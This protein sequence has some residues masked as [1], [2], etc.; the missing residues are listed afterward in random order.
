MTASAPID[1]MTFEEYLAFE[2]GSDLKH[3]YIRGLVFAMAGTT[4][5]HNKICR[6]VVGLLDRR[7]DGGPCEPFVSDVKLRV[8][9]TDA[10]FYP[11]VFVVCGDGGRDQDVYATDARLVI[12]VLSPSTDAHDRGEKLKHYIRLPGLQ[13]YVLVDSR[14]RSIEIY[15]RADEGW[16][17][18]PLSEEQPVLL[19]SVDLRTTFDAIYRRVDLDDPADRPA[20][21]PQH[22]LGET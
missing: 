15:R 11:D 2:E 8:A 21:G 18:L 20:R 7:L 12:E 14:R 13:E 5:A 4:R 6:N 9:T 19:T 17:Y 10:T 16:S 22:D 1:L 3:E